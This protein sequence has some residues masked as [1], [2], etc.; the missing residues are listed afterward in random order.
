MK[1]ILLIVTIQFLISMSVWGEESIALK[2]RHYTGGQYP[3]FAPDET[4]EELHPVYNIYTIPNT[5]SIVIN[6]PSNDIKIFNVKTGALSYVLKGHKRKVLTTIVSKD[7]KTLISSSFDKTIKVW[8][9]EKRVLVKSIKI[10]KGKVIKLIFGLNEQTIMG[11][12]YRNRI[13]WEWDIDTGNL[14][15]EFK[16]KKKPIISLLVDEKEGYLFTGN[17]DGSVKV[18]DIR[19]DFKELFSWHLA[20]STPSSMYQYKEKII[21]G[22]GS[23]QIEFWKK[24]GDRYVNSKRRMVEH[25]YD[26]SFKIDRDIMLLSNKDGGIATYD[27]AKD[28]WLREIFDQV[29]YRSAMAIDSKNKIVV[30]GGNYGCIVGSDMETGKELYRISLNKNKSAKKCSV[31]G[32]VE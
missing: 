31:R 13:V 28:K 4:L 24:S 2:I 9:L 25:T 20:Y 29:N 5:E 16:E 18:L 12:K 21:V 14:I 27:I 3:M 26:S 10:P 7:G 30:T 17:N 8:D 6:S 23:S 11:I 19:N 15:K 32:I 1:K 22:G